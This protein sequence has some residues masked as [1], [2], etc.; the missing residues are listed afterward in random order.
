MDHKL[1]GRFDHLRKSL[2][3]ELNK[4]ANLDFY[5]NGSIRDYCPNGDSGGNKECKTELDK[6]KA[7][8]IWLFEQ[9]IVNRVSN[10]S[11]E[12]TDIFIIYIIIWFNYMINLK[13]DNN[14]NNLN[15]FY[16]KYT[17][18]NTHYN[19]CK[20]NNNDCSNTLKEKMGYKSFKEIIDKR[21][22]LLNNN[23][24]YMP[25]LYDAFKLLCKMYTELDA[26]D[27][28][29]KKYLENAKNFV[30]KYD[31]LN[32]SDIAED[33]PYYQVLSTLSNDYNNFKN[34][35][36]KNKVDC[37]DIPSLSSIK[38]TKNSEEV[39]ELSELSEQSFED[40]SSSSSVTN[41]LIPVLS[42]FGAT[43]IFLGISYKYS[44]FGFRK[45]SQKQHLREKLKK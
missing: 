33:N 19:Y 42:I 40:T 27:K 45:R 21:K 8:F 4:S 31:E 11:K 23:F 18:G 44:L 34:Y 38:T 35:C 15:D 2:S 37:S 26:S 30:D 10:L 1:C 13:P 29:S 9:N 32:V 12:Q 5:S 6:I 39:S 22:D 24:E 25:K 17:E 36:E 43:A 3:D 16:T 7:G 41:K 20:K 14:T 28:Q